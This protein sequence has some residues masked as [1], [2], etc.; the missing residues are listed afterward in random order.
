MASISQS[1]LNKVKKLYYIKK[2]SMK[3]IGSELNTSIDCVAYFMRKNNLKRRTFEQEQKLRFDNKKPTFTLRKGDKDTK[4]LRAI[5]AMLY[6]GEGY[7]GNDI[8]PAKSV[9]FA[10][11]DPDMIKLFLLFLRNNFSLTEKKFRILLYCYSDQDVQSLIRFWSKETGIPIESFTK[12]YVRRNF[13]VNA[14]KMKYGLIHIRY[15]DK[16]LLLEIKKMIDSYKQKY[17]K[18]EASVA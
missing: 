6:W 5:G 4:E 3:E 16:K 12:P 1:K 10:N 9:D 18:S 17:I 7:K 15:Y 13:N 2:Y 8:T 14:R 11:S